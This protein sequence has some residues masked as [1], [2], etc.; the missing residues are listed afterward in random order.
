MNDSDTLKQ[1]VDT[2]VVCDCILTRTTNFP[3]NVNSEAG[4]KKNLPK[5][6]QKY[7]GLQIEKGQICQN[8][9]RRL[10]NLE[11][12]DDEFYELCQKTLKQTMEQ[13]TK[14]TSPARPS[15][16]RLFLQ[17][18]LKQSN[19]DTIGKTIPTYQTIMSKS[20]IFS[21]ENSEAPIMEI[22]Q[23]TIPVDQS[24]KRLDIYT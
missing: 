5:L 8:C 22:S 16:N 14:C 11:K 24:C 7:G 23:S 2:C 15:I 1:T 3:Q 6:L 10:L 21:I 13:D 12:A 19:T 4:L 20:P 17:A 18:D 9:R